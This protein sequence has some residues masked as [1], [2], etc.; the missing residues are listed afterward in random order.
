MNSGQVNSPGNR[1][2]IRSRAG[3]AII[4]LIGLVI[5]TLASA[6][7]V[8]AS[9]GDKRVE[10]ETGDPLCNIG[11]N[12]TGPLASLDTSPLRIGWYLDYQ[13]SPSPIEPGGA[14]YAPVIKLRQVGAD[15]YSYRPRGSEL[16]SAIAANQ[17]AVWFVGN[18]PDSIWQDNIEP[19]VYAS[20]YHEL[21]HLIKAADPSSMIIAGSIVQPTPI[22]LQYL[23]LILGSYQAAHGEAMPVDGWAIHNFILNEVSCEYDPGNCW[24]AEIPPGIDADYGEILSIE[25]SDNMGLFVERIERFRHWMADRGYAG[26]PVYLSEYGILMPPDYG[27]G[28]PPARVNDFMNNTF[29]YM[30]SATDPWL[31]DPHDE[32]RLIQRLSWYSTSAEPNG[33]LFEQNSSGTYDLSAMGLNFADYV[34]VIKSEVD[35]YPSRIFTDPPSPFSQGESITIT[36]KATVANSG[37]AITSTRP[38]T[39]RFYNGDPVNG[40]LQ[41]GED[42]LVS[43]TGCG[44]HKTVSV[45]WPSRAPGGYQVYAVVD[46]DEEIGEADED[47]NISYQSIVVATDR[48]FGP[49]VRK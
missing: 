1:S 25:D 24:G 3:T 18:E 19:H 34:A 45:V 4:L 12:V 32:Q 21:Y 37:N 2:I 28:F 30:L 7:S 35:L 36:L 17:G 48:V 5:F 42:Q 39:V 13:A 29:N 9:G 38:V 23:D 8:K 16:Q 6:V 47:N 33:W 20:A 49:L 26:L 44:D 31:G 10:Q 14:D 40:G 41:I 11:V 27:V 15:G 43:L 22:R 46:P